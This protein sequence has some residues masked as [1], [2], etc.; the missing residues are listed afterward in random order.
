MEPI[1]IEYMDPKSEI[2]EQGNNMKMFKK[3][4]ESWLISCYPDKEEIWLRDGDR[5]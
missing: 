1:I 2:G 3:S 4:Y 5:K